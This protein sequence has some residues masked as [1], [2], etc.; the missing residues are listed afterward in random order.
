MPKNTI[1]ARIARKT[2]NE[3]NV[4]L[5]FEYPDLEA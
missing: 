5:L 3:V 4:P 1:A 2:S